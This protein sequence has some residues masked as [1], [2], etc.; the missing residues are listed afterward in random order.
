MPVVL[1]TAVLGV[2]LV[3]GVLATLGLYLITERET[4]DPRVVDRSEAER[5]AK[6]RGGRQASRNRDDA[7]RPDPERPVGDRSG[8]GGSESSARGSES[9]ERE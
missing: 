4:S 8:R 5:L 3:L 1:T 2:V 6:A 7:G 9:S